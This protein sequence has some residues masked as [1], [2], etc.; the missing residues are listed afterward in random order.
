LFQARPGGGASSRGDGWS[1]IGEWHTVGGIKFG[2]IEV[3]E[4]RFPF[5]FRRHEF[6]PG[7]GGAGQHRGG[8]GV[9]LD[10]V[11]ETKKT[12]LANTA[13]DG[14]RHGSC[15]ILGGL[16]GQP[17]EYSLI[18]TARPPRILRTKETGIEI[19]P[20][21]VLQIRSAGGGGWG[22]LERRAAEKIRRDEEQ[23]LAEPCSVG[24]R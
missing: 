15:G 20:G 18:S 1:S 9:E 23:G 4:V 12:A 3:A 21:D 2:S 13:G 8:L 7:S 5:H 11:V 6:R 16:D 17:H 10:L 19:E 14:V 22:P 24:P